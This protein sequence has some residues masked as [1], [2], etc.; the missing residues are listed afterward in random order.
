MDHPPHSRPSLIETLDNPQALAPQRRPTHHIS[1][2]STVLQPV[3]ADHNNQANVPA[4]LWPPPDYLAPEYGFGVGEDFELDYEQLDINAMNNHP[5]ATHFYPK[6]NGPPSE[7]SPPPTSIQRASPTPSNASDVELGGSP[8]PVAN[9]DTRTPAKRN[10]RSKW[11]YKDLKGLAAA[12]AELNPYGC[13][14]GMTQEVWANIEKQ[15][16]DRHLC[17]DIS[18]GSLKNKMNALLIHHAVSGSALLHC[19]LLMLLHRTPIALREPQ[20]R[21]SSVTKSTEPPSRLWLIVPPD[22]RRRP[23]TGQKHR[24]LKLSL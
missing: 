9:L 23:R 17:V 14:H 24:R 7:L 10:S 1:H 15:L 5:S 8:E 16:K 3:R 13:K 4:V 22:F 11:R 18:I 12:V 19:A 20:S 2:Q 6:P 21:R